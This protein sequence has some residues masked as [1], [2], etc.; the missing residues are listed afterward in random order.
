MGEQQHLPEF[1]MRATSTHKQP[2]QRADEPRRTR[3]PFAWV[4]AAALA[5]L[6][7]TQIPLGAQQFANS[8]S[9]I[10][11]GAHASVR[12]NIG[13][14][15]PELLVLNA[16]A[17]ATA[18]WQGEHFTEYLIKYAVAANTSWTVAVT[19]LPGGVTVL[20]ADGVWQGTVGAAV[21]HGNRTDATEVLLRV[22]I[23]NGAPA[24]WADE[25]GVELV[26]ALGTR[27]AR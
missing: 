10:G 6:A 9:A 20:D 4:A 1:T 2:A 25:M 19:T 8:A 21:D 13:A 7:A 18:T 3:V 12:V 11:P 5:L 17:P 27:S 14:R 16:T 15:M 22:R 26:G 23:A 24:T